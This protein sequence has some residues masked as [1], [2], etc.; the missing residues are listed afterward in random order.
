MN[1]IV[2]GDKELCTKSYNEA[3]N[4]NVDLSKFSLQ[5][6]DKL[7]YVIENIDSQGNI[8]GGVISSEALETISLSEM[9]WVYETLAKDI[10]WALAS[11]DPERMVLFTL[12]KV[13]LRKQIFDTDGPAINIKKK[14]S[15]TEQIVQE[16]PVEQ[17]L[18]QQPEE[19]VVVA[20]VVEKDLTWEGFIVD[21]KK[22]QKSLAANLERGNILGEFNFSKAEMNLEV[23]FTEENK[24]FLDFLKENDA[25]RTI[26][27]ELAYFF[28]LDEGNIEIL[29]T[30]VDDQTKEK[31]NF[32]SRVEIEEHSFNLKQEEKRQNIVENKFVKEAE[33]IFNTKIDKVILNTKK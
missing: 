13:C 9:L 30:L 29:L 14:E 18:V 20:P 19:V 17:V 24:I 32:K 1:A 8:D 2:T 3:L 23:G 15:A 4:E 16:Q 6:L 12:A 27:E 22:T 31:R 11:I 7:F 21:L 5:I 33:K 25:R 28:E 26:K 10:Q